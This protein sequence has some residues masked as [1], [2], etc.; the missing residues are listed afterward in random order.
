MALRKK[1]LVSL[2]WTAL[3]LGAQRCGWVYT[4]RTGER[5]QRGEKRG[6]PDHASRGYEGRHVGRRDSEEQAV[7][8]LAQV[9]GGISAD[10]SAEQRE[11]GYPPEHEPNH[12]AARRADGEANAESRDR[13]ATEYAVTPKMPT[14][15]KTRASTENAVTKPAVKRGSASA[16]A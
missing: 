3:S 16:F 2:T 4:Q 15:A 8:Q 12:V 10:H 5:H 6:Q 11:F 7:H 9:G 14:P 13:W 1:I